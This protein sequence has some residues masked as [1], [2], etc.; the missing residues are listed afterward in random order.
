MAVA[1]TAVLLTRT[2][3][4]ELFNRGTT[5]VDVAGWSVQYVSAT[6]AGT[7]STTGL[8][9]TSS[10]LIQPG[11][12][13]LVQED[14]GAGGTTNLLTPDATG[15]ITM[16]TGTGKVALLSTTTALS[17]ACPTSA[18]IQ[19]LVGYGSTS[20]TANFCFEGSG[21]TP[22]PGNTTAAFRKSGGCIDT[23]DNAA[24][25]VI[26][27]PNPRNTSASVNDCSTGFR[28]D[29]SINDV[30]VTEGDSGTLNANFT[31]TLSAASAQTVTVAYATADGNATAGADYQSNSGT[32]TFSPG[33]TT[34]PVTVAVNGDTLDETNE[35]F[36]VNLSNPTNAAILDNQGLGTI[37]DND[38][39]PSLSIN[40]L[41]NIAEGNSGTSTA[42]FTV[43]LS[44]ASG[45]TVTV[46][47]AT[48]DGTA[49][50]ADNDYVATAGTLTFNPGDTAKTIPV[51]INGD[52]TFEP[53]E[54]ILV[55]LT[56]PVN[57][58]ISDSQ[59]QGTIKNDDASPNPSISIDDV[60][61]NEGDTGTTLATFNV[62]LS[63][64]SAQT[65]TVNYATADGTA[66][67]PSDYQSTSGTLTFNP[68]DLSKPISVLVNGD[69]INEAVCETFL[70]NLSSPTNAVFGD[71]QGQG[72]I[73]DNDGTKL[74]ISQI[75]GGGGNSSATYANDFIEIFNRG[76]SAISLNG[77][78][79]QY[80]P[81][82]GTS[83]TYSVTTLPNVTLQAGHY[84]LI[85]EATGGAVGSP[86][87]SPDLTPGTTID[88]AAGAGRVALVNGTTALS[89]TSCPTGST[90]L[91]FVGY[92][93]TA[94][95]REGAAT[96]DNAPGPSN[97]T[98]SVQRKQNGC[99][100]IGL[101]GPAATGD[102]TA[103]SVGPRNTTTSANLCSCSTSYSSMSILDGDSWKTSLATLFIDRRALRPSP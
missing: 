49:T 48:A 93:S 40:D 34:Q 50:T 98:T 14:Q 88:L 17:G 4:I 57:A 33:V 16:T 74:V 80:A 92:G 41:P 26:S 2:I 45:Q 25:L 1:E 24:D 84:Y 65:V 90:I 15:T 56:S 102:F 3:S 30:T 6:G 54:T 68:G 8:C 46:T 53:D 69:T 67:A 61:V 55:N 62:S 77:L 28:P 97:N 101:N 18:S 37:T 89:R 95:C 32:L 72:S 52:T 58:T 23:N 63:F 31:V 75:Y 35:T 43:S 96:S 87:P 59:G 11:R 81:A 83:G 12:Y 19:D 39:T 91:D 66:K 22:A 78:S 103:P 38:Q 27:V 70:V 20:S 100:D 7:W 47:Y 60:T 94:I 29:I 51:T 21:P 76:D 85:Q 99:Q 5:I 9:A 44:A 82:T 42:T 73:T 79:V 71:N 64:A 86:L 10:C 13:Y 36:F